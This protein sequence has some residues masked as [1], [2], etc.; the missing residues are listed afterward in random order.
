MQT[1]TKHNDT[2]VAPKLTTSMSPEESKAPLRNYNQDVKVR[3][4]TQDQEVRE[5][6]A[7]AAI[8]T[9]AEKG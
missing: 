1:I 9:K 3:K 8:T 5:G 7:E 4:T 2:M 6:K